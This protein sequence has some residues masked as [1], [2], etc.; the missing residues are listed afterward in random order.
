MEG[1][2]KVRLWKNIFFVL[3]VVFV[4][5]IAIQVFLAGYATFMDPVKWHIHVVFVRVIEFLPLLM[6]VISFIGK[7]TKSFRW[8]SF[9]LFGLIILM[10]A[11]AN[12][13]NAGAFHP[14]IALV[15]FWLSMVVAN[16]AWQVVKTHKVM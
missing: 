2:G 10:Y 5:T 9:G 12:I 8:Q 16:R 1:E 14:V 7:L 15:M 3:A 11:T 6:V 13:P 4:V